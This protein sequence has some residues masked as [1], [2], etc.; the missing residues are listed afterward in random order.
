ML[1]LRTVYIAGLTKTTT[2]NTA[3]HQ[4]EHGSVLGHADKGHQRIV[5]KIRAVQYGHDKATY[6]CGSLGTERLE[7]CQGTVF[8]VFR[9]IKRRHVD[10]RQRRNFF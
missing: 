8:V 7:G 4:F 5:N 2:A 9:L 3:A 10:A 1:A 6:L